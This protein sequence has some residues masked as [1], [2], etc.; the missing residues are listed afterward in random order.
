MRNEVFDPMSST[1]DE[2]IKFIESDNELDEQIKNEIIEGI[3][4]AGWAFF[5]SLPVIG[6]FTGGVR[7][8]VDIISTRYKINRQL[9]L[10]KFV[11]GIKEC[12]D[13]ISKY[14]TDDN[15]S[16]VIKKL[17][18]DDEDSKIKFYTRLTVSLSNIT[19]DE[20]SKS[21]RI[22]LISI[23]RDLTCSEIELAIKFYTYDN[24]ELVGYE[25]KANQLNKISETDDG[26]TLKYINA[27]LN[28]GLIVDPNKGKVPNIQYYKVTKLLVKLITMICDVSKLLP[29][30]YDEKEKKNVDIILESHGVISNVSSASFISML[31]ERS[32][33]AAI[34][35][36]NE[37]DNHEYFSKYYLG[38]INT[39][40]PGT[41]DS[42]VNFDIYDAYYKF[43]ERKGGSSVL[44]IK[45]DHS[46]NKN[47]NEYRMKLIDSIAITIKILDSSRK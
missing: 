42:G 16:F 13:D 28:N 27:L 20:L 3:K 1:N 2:L 34:V 36:R 12:S 33:T 15:V 5:E 24:Y 45:T 37:M 6:E 17:L 35:G 11:S 31:K 19:S 26:F 18:E 39:S 8:A 14:L 32:I 41:Y 23:L 29:E 25:S 43:K 10:Y 22:N 4:E 7:R 30:C 40:G 9:K 44:K 38:W 46:F 21:D 47:I